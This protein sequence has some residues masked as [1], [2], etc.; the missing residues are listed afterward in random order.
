MGQ[1]LGPFAMSFVPKV[2]GLMVMRWCITVVLLYL[3][4]DDGEVLVPY[5]VYYYFDYLIVGRSCSFYWYRQWSEQEK[6]GDNRRL[7]VKKQKHL[8]VPNCS[9]TPRKRLELSAPIRL[10][11]QNLPHYPSRQYRILLMIAPPL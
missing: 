5:Q 3:P 7:H 11:D 10:G 6:G 9:F 1:H 4:S 2:M 8:F